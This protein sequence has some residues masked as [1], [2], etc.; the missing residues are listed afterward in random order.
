[1]G[2][3]SKALEKIASENQIKFSYANNRIE[4]LKTNACRFEEIK[5]FEL[6]NLLFKNTKFD[7]TIVG[8]LIVVYKDENKSQTPDVDNIQSQELFGDTLN[9]EDSIKISN[10][11]ILN[12]ENFQIYSP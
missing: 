12:K 8:R 4:S 3:L 7:Y 1:G 2:S 11:S 5:L 6:L 10:D 9:L